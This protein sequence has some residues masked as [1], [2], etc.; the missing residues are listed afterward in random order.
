MYNHSY[1]DVNVPYFLARVKTI[2]QR[3]YIN[4]LTLQEEDFNYIATCNQ[5]IAIVGNPAE[6]IDYCGALWVASLLAI[7]DDKEYYFRL[8]ED[9]RKFCQPALD[10]INIFYTHDLKQL[11]AEKQAEAVA[12]EAASIEPFYNMVAPAA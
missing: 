3:N 8:A 9:F 10:N 5:T 4:Q 2:L 1:T 11:V 6:K 12:R 7:G